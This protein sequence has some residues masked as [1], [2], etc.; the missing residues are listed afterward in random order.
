MHGVCHDARPKLVVV[1]LQSS[2]VKLARGYCACC[3]APACN[4][5]KGK[6]QTVNWTC[7]EWAT[8]SVE[9]DHGPEEA[10]A[11]DAPLPRRALPKSPLYWLCPIPFDE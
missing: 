7:F 8:S 2:N 10:A 11:A 3:C 4:G 5:Q 1:I 9:S 6:Q